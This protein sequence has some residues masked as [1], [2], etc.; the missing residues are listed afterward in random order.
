ML[1]AGGVAI[2][3]VGGLAQLGA[4]L[5]QGRPQIAHGVERAARDLV[6]SPELSPTPM[7]DSPVRAIVIGTDDHRSFPVLYTQAVLGVGSATLYIDAQLLAHPWYRAQL[8]QRLPS[9]PDVD[10]PMRLIGAIEASPEL[11]HL[12]IYLANVFSRPA[13]SRPKVPEGMLWRVLPHPESPRFIAAEWSADAILERHLAACARMGAQPEDFV[14]RAR[15]PWSDDLAFAYVEKARRLA[16]AL[17]QDGRSD[18]I[19]PVAEALA[20]ATGHEL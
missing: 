17:A 10:K 20:R 9:L 2:G 3:L 11:D 14:P 18:A 16:A 8:R 19:A 12:P 13:A 15:D 4:V 5:D 1:P 6:L 7:A